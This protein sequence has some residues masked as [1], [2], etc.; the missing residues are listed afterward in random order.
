MSSGTSSAM[1]TEKTVSYTPTE[2]SDASNMQV[3]EEG[4]VLATTL[5][6][7]LSEGATSG[8]SQGKRSRIQDTE[9]YRRNANSSADQS[10]EM[11]RND[12]EGRADARASRP[13]KLRRTDADPDTC[14]VHASSNHNS[15]DGNGST[16]HGDNKRRNGNTESTRRID[17]RQDRSSTLTSCEQ[18]SR[19]R[20][21]S[22]SRYSEHAYDSDKYRQQSRRGSRR[23]SHS[24]DYDRQRRNDERARS[25]DRAS[26]KLQTHY[27]TNNSCKYL[28]HHKCY[29]DL[30]RDDYSR[31]N[32]YHDK[33][34]YY[35]RHSRTRTDERESSSRCLKEDYHH[36]SNCRSK[37]TNDAHRNKHRDSSDHRRKGQEQKSVIGISTQSQKDE[38]RNK[39]EKSMGP[40][41]VENIVIQ[42]PDTIEMNEE[43]LIEERRRRRQE[44]LAKHKK[45]P[46]S[47]QQNNDTTAVST[48]VNLNDASSAVE[49]EVNGKC[50]VLYSM[51]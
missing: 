50:I 17:R 38:A 28:Y 36:S 31:Y 5:T 32:R 23:R 16:I 27:E 43:Q 30:G 15:D 3:L 19:S 11:T 29:Y 2:H 1:Q 41:I 9:R 51:T 47:E 46:L 45:L 24:R 14:I 22:R 40:Q 33:V 8:Q 21:R 18:R 37:D 49:T 12:G 20:S 34:D 26:R 6:P 44:I 35:S 10:G 42:D 25:R 48:P 4:E 39:I 7:P 13:N